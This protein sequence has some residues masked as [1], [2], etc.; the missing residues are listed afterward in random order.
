MMASVKARPVVTRVVPN[1]AALFISL[2][3]F[4]ANLSQFDICCISLNPYDVDI[5][6]AGDFAQFH[7]YFLKQWVEKAVPKGA[8]DPEDMC[9]EV[10]VDAAATEYSVELEGAPLGA[11]SAQAREFLGAPCKST[12]HTFEYHSCHFTLS[13]IYLSFYFTTR[14]ALNALVA[15]LCLITV[16]GKSYYDPTNLIKSLRM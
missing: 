12:T 8:R 6:F 9:F 11:T 10:E 14:E 7:S 4:A 13:D 1:D 2:D 16:D 15:K 3:Q 5:Y